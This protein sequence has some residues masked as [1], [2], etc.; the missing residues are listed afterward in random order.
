MLPAVPN[1]REHKRRTISHFDRIGNFSLG[2]FLPLVKAVDRNLSVAAFG[3][4]GETLGLHR[5]FLLG[6]FVLPE[7]QEKVAKK[8]PLPGEVPC[9]RVCLILERIRKSMIVRIAYD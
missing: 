8:A 6:R 1:A 9:T 4:C 7:L 5:A 2:R 3:K